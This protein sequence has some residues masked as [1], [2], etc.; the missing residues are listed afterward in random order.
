MGSLNRY[1]KMSK[2]TTTAKKKPT[3]KE[4]LKDMADVITAVTVIGSALIAVGTWCINQ[5]NAATNEKLDAMS[6][7]MSGLEL[8]SART[9]LLLLMNHYPENDNEI[10]KVAEYYFQELDGDWYMTELF[11]EWAENRG[12]DIDEIVKLKK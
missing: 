7:Q 4:R 10:M 1:M 5:A 9:Q 8:D 3:L 6:S 12:I 2:K 11:S